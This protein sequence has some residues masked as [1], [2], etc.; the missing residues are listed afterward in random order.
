MRRWLREPLLHFVL[1]GAGLFALDALL[2]ERTVEAGG[3]DIVVSQGRIENLAALF[4]KTWQRPPTE[5]ELRGLV[6][7]YVLEL[8][9]AP[10]VTACR[11]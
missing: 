2:R 9:S 5:G 7:D 4:A 1:L 10:F 6:D 11:R 3:G 8:G